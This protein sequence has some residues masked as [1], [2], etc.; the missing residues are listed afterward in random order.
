LEEAKFEGVFPAVITP[1]D[2]EGE[3]VFEYLK[4]VIHF[5]LRKGLN[6]F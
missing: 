2:Q 4:D 1:F 5:Q 3:V 6:I